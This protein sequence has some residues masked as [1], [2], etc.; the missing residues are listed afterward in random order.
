PRH[1]QR[2]HHAMI[3]SAVDARTVKGT[4]SD[5]QPVGAFFNIGA[6]RLQCPE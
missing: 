2:H 4:F 1:R 6:H 5:D 3:V